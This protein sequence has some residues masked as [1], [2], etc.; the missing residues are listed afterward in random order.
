MFP[1]G[2]WTSSMMPDV[3][4][5]PAK[6]EQWKDG[7][8]ASTLVLTTY[9]SLTRSFMLWLAVLCEARLTSPRTPPPSEQKV[10]R[11]LG[12]VSTLRT[13]AP[14]MAEGAALAGFSG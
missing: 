5:V 1:H 2:N 6:A 8:M 7:G 11:V 4:E 9:S 3:E 14:G 13:G 10:Q 12:S